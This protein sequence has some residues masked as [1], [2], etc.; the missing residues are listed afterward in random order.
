MADIHV[1]RDLRLTLKTLL[2]P[3]IPELGTEN[4]IIFDSPGDI[5]DSDTTTKLTAFLYHI[6]ENSFMRNTPPTFK[7][8]TEKKVNPLTLDLHIMFVA[9]ANNRETEIIVMERLMRTLYDN[10]LLKGEILEENLITSG[11][12]EIK[13][14]PQTLSLDDLNKLWSTFPNKPFKLSKSYIFT[15]VKIPS[16]RIEEVPRVR[17]KIITSAATG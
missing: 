10:S 8:Y 2:F 14:V 7:N 12:D 16:E 1:I 3:L 17:E 13:I 15:P 5:D 9:Y 11:N 4:D 6:V